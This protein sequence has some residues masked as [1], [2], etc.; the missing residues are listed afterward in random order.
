[1]KYNSKLKIKHYKTITLKDVKGFQQAERLQRNG[2]KVIS[3]GFETIT[4]IKE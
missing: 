4:M 1:M 3:V 2:W